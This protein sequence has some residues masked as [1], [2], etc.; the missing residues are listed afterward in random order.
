[1]TGAPLARGSAGHAAGRGLPDPRRQHRPGH[2]P[3]LG[4]DLAGVPVV[5]E[6]EH[7]TAPTTRSARSPAPTARR[8]AQ[9]IQPI[10]PIQ[11]DRT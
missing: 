3:R 7:M 9:P 6:T 8:T 11:E 4:Q 1:M 10:Q 5:D 2:R